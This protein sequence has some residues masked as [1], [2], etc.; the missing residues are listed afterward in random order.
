[1]NGLRMILELSGSNSR[2]DGRSIVVGGWSNLLND[3][4]WLLDNWG[5][6]GGVFHDLFSSVNQSRIVVDRSVSSDGR[7]HSSVVVGSGGSG[8]SGVVRSVFSVVL[9]DLVSVGDESHLLS[10]VHRGIVRWVR[11]NSDSVRMVSGGGSG[12]SASSMS[13]GTDLVWLSISVVSSTVG[14][15]RAGRSVVADGVA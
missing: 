3:W 12:H 2:F 1:M 14:G 13:R 5:S 9:K 6:D 11:W 7:L 8:S 10:V 15:N 4:K